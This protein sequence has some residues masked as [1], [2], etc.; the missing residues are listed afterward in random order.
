M[1][2]KCCP[3]Q[4]PIAD[5]LSLSMQ[6][7]DLLQTA[8]DV[9]W[10]LSQIHAQEVLQMREKQQ[11]LESAMAPLRARRLSSEVAQAI[12]DIAEPGMQGLMLEVS[13][14]L[15]QEL[16]VAFADPGTHLE[17]SE[18]LL[19]ADVPDPAVTGSEAVVVERQSE[20]EG[21][22][23]PE[24]V[25]V[26]PDGKDR[27]LS[28]SDDVEKFV[29]QRGDNAADIGNRKEFHFADDD[30]VDKM[31]V[32]KMGRLC[33]R[34]HEED[35]ANDHKLS[36]WLSSTLDKIFAE[37]HA[38]PDP[39]IAR[40]QGRRSKRINDLTLYGI[41]VSPIF[42]LTTT[43]VIVLNACLVAWEIEVMCY[44]DDLP[45]TLDAMNVLCDVFFL[46]EVILRLSAFRMNFFLGDTKFWNMFDTILA[47]LPL[48]Q[49]ILASTGMPTDA[50][51]S[52]MASMKTLKMVRVARILRVFKIFQSLS[53]LVLMLIHS[54]RDLIWALLL[55]MVVIYT[56]SLF[57]T[58]LCTSW[59]KVNS[60]LFVSS[61]DM[62]EQWDKDGE[63]TVGFAAV[64]V[65]RYYG[66][67]GR[68]VYTLTQV[69]L[70]G[71]SW[72]EVCTPLFRVDAICPM[73]LLV[74]ISFSL[75]AVVNL[76]T[77]IFVDNATQ[78]AKGQREYLIAQEMEVKEKFLQQ[79]QIFFEEIDEDGSGTVNF[80]EIE[81]MI[82][83]PTLQA[84]FRVLGFD[85][86][87]AE[88]LFNLLDSDGNAEVPLDEF[89]DGCLR[90]K[91]PARSIDVH[92]LIHESREIRKL[93]EPDFR[94]KALKN[95]ANQRRTTLK[96][97]F[98]ESPLQV[99][100]RS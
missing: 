65:K 45:V 53:L 11:L 21:V 66:N 6:T 57:L 17:T 88:R 37:V 41:A 95:K 23:E 28:I 77:G 75:I 68:T 84:Y 34:F 74:Y 83:D 22:A 9:L 15:R 3:A 42:T 51:L 90:L 99:L 94:E 38:D 39:D 8:E 19:P 64:E 50:K 33:A 18:E 80:S 40:L 100:P 32:V 31:E 59:L 85:T 91:G 96:S 4:K 60:E 93:L 24:A 47:V 16:K 72:H 87:E 63:M 82:Q 55:I 69:V 58:S 79:M 89:L 56:F 49:M 13:N 25:V 86:H 98:H 20:G 54:M 14:N 30:P 48:I 73:L 71:V 29:S 97:Q 92:S 78:S 26:E 43:C 46:G 44:R 2:N 5:C 70:G 52:V 76:I 10:R 7:N 81:L 12:A 36:S 27:V 62:W 67:V 61:K 1:E 35:E